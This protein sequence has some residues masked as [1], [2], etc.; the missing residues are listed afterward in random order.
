MDSP[1][2]PLAG[3]VAVTDHGVAEGGAG[4]PVL[5]AGLVE[6]FENRVAIEGEHVDD[7]KVEVKHAGHRVA[8]AGLGSGVAF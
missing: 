4:Q 7:G 2:Q 5:G 6:S 8:C 1:N 3:C